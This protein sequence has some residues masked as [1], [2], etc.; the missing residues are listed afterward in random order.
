MIIF[1]I[2]KFKKIMFTL[3]ELWYWY[4]SLEP[5]IDTET[6]KIHHSKHHQTYIDK[7]NLWIK[8]SDLEEYSNDDLIKLVSDMSNSDP[9][10]TSIIKNHWWWHINHTIFWEIM[11]PWWTEKWLE[12]FKQMIISD[13]A[14]FENFQK[15]F[16]DKALSL[17]GSWW[18]WLE[19]E[20]WKLQIT[21][22]PNQENPYMYNKKPI[23]WIDLWEHAY[24]LSN[25]NRR[26]EYISKRRNIINRNI[27]TNK[28][29]QK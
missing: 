1:Y 26:P 28:I 22:Y 20:N 19:S 14:S 6:M 23:L 15:E 8:W 9:K 25:Q 10:F 3:P 4:E 5:N 29:S 11:T 24:Y 7:L 18:T 12:S 2:Y 13:F 16:N 17:F 27:V 21:N